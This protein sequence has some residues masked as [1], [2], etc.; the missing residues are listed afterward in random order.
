MKM[1]PEVFYLWNSDY[2][3]VLPFGVGPCT[4]KSS[5]LN[6]IFMSSFEQ[7]VKSVYFQSTIDVDFGYHFIAKRPLNI[8]DIHGQPT[9][10]IIE[11]LQVLFDGFIV[12][13]TN[14]YL[15]ENANQ[16]FKFK[17]RMFSEI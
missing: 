16:L 5:L 12:Q 10:E 17:D 4:G 8:A 15:Q 13:V 2:P 14:N 1:I 7:H 11:K 9:R 6:S 3:T